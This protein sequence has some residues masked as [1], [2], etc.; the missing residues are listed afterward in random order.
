MELIA[1]ILMA[2]GSFGAAV[3]CYVLSGRLTRFG[4]LE[5]GMG[6][7]IA[8]LSAQVDDMTSALEQARGAAG[9]SASGLEALTAKAEGLAGRLEILV[10]SLHDLPGPEHAVAAKPVAEAEQEASRLRFVRRR[11]ARDA[12]EPVE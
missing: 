10:A 4:T 6:G 9:A 5:T 2:A 12:L 7:A 3:Y 11:S 1:D 8:V